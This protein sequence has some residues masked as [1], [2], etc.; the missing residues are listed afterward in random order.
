MPLLLQPSLFPGSGTNSESADLHILRLGI[1]PRAQACFNY[2]ICS[3]LV[4]RHT[5]YMF[6]FTYLQLSCKFDIHKQQWT[7]LFPQLSVIQKSFLH[8]LQQQVFI[9]RSHH[10]RKKCLL[11]CVCKVSRTCTPPYLLQNPVFNTLRAHP[12][13]LS[14]TKCNCPSINGQ[15]TNFI[16]FHVAL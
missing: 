16:L 7:H 14:C 13:P 15:S 9:N 12:G 10:Y 4:K 6:S 8:C 1:E 3:V 2:C 5:L 11:D